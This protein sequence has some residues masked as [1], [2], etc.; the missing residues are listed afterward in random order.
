[1]FYRV[2]VFNQC[3]AR[4]RYLAHTGH[5]FQLV[6]PQQNPEKTWRSAFW[7]LPDN[8]VEVDWATADGGVRGGEYDLVLCQTLEDLVVARQ[9]GIPRLFVPLGLLG[10]EAGVSPAA[11]RAALEQLRPFLAGVAVAF[12]SEKQRLSWGLA[13][14]LLGSAVDPEEFAPATG[15]EAAVLRFNT[16]AADHLS[17]FGIQDAVLGGEFPSFI[18]DLETGQLDW[19]GVKDLLRRHRVLCSSLTEGHTVGYDA[20]VLAAMAAGMPVVSTANSA[21]PVVDGYNGFI[22]ND[23]RYLREKLH[24]VLS[25]PDLAAELGRNARQTVAE[26]FNIGDHV[27]AWNAAFAEC[28]GQTASGGLP[29]MVAAP[30]VSIAIPVFNK[31]EF[32]EACL[33]ALAENTDDDPTYEVIVINNASSDWTQYLLHAFEGDLRVEHNDENEGFARANNQAAAMAQGEYLLFLNNDTVVQPGWLRAMVQLADSDPSIGIVGAKLLYPESGTIQ[34]AG[35]E[36]INGVP[37][38]IHREVAA[39]DPRVNAVCDFD[40][41]T[42]ACMLVRRSL[43]IELAGFDEEFLNGV[44][45]VDLCL[46]AREL[47]WRVVYCPTSVVEHHEGSSEGRY[48]HVRENLQRFVDRW[49]GR[50]DAEGRLAIAAA[51]VAAT[52]RKVS[53]VVPQPLGQRPIRGNWEGPFL[54]YA[55]LATVNRELVLA[56]LDDGRCELGLLQTEPSEMADAEI[57]ERLGPIAEGLDQ[58]LAGAIDFHLRHHW[59]PDF[60]RPAA[61]KLV[62][63]QPWEFGRIP[64]DWVE[65]IGENVAQIWAYTNYV[66]DCYIASGIDPDIVEVVRLGVDVKR[67]HPGLSGLDLPTDKTCKFLFVGGTLERKGIDCLLKA[68]RSVFTPDDDVCLVIKDMGTRSFYENQTAGEQIRA[69]QNDPHCAD[70]LYLTEDLP[71]ADIPRLYAACDCLVHPY[72]GEGFGLPV[73]EAMACGLPVVVTQGGACDDFCNAETAYLVPARRIGVKFPDGMEAAGQPW[74]LEPDLDQLKVQLRQVFA[75]R[76]EARQRGALA[77]EHIAGHFTWQH[78][79]QDAYA[80]LAKLSQQGQTLPASTPSTPVAE[81]TLVVLGDVAEAAVAVVM[82]GLGSGTVRRDIRGGAETSL[83]AELEVVR[84]ETQGDFLVFI[85]KGEIVDAAGVGLLVEHLRHQQDIAVALPS[86]SGEAGEVGLVELDVAEGGLFVFRRQALEAIGG[87]NGSF[88]TEAVLCEAGRQIGRQGGRVVRVLECAMVGKHCP[89]DAAYGDEL[90]SVRSLAE[91]DRMRAVGDDEAALVAY[92]RAVAAK[93]NFVEAIVVLAALLMESGQPLEATEYL[94]GLVQMDQDS[95]QAHN[96]LGL[97]HYQAGQVEKARSIM[98]RAHALNP[99]YVETLVNL[100][101]LE[102]EQGNPPQALDYLEKAAELEPDNRDVIV[103]TGIMYAQSGNPAA[104]ISLLR[105]YLQL[106]P[107]DGQAASSLADVLIQNGEF[108]AARELAED[109]LAL[110][111][112]YPVAQAILERIR[113]QEDQDQE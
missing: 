24:A 112:Q 35:I 54:V 107:R 100:A 30:R 82:A 44:E 25:A 57:G 69:L 26:H 46:R 6:H 56:L 15:A 21:S 18:A 47:G 49:Q 70:I 81:S 39:D 101:V 98:Q 36:L 84:R 8:V 10:T 96:Y 17:G 86:P 91:G 19:V 61:G 94:Q 53:G 111:P 16:G 52:A 73:A 11:R 99:T 72:R 62:L 65:P 28:L 37:D 40:M 113:G 76:E 77:A 13:G 103:N 66:R 63:M 55:S 80:A 9:W 79:A 58:P 22:S 2:L 48:D 50:F 95:F 104:G 93:G 43:F 34:H 68:Y 102:W 59:P 1:M 105:E 75:H 106:N 45:D 89:L 90:E 74:M 71:E 31:A 20:F 108:A 110:D 41:V 97:A 23:Y 51:A 64:V 87:F 109:L 14:S 5:S 92:R 3:E 85:G 12:Y 88:R 42:G 29:P 67:F 32:T 7:P 83:S 38:H 33:F 60:S 78:A 27:A 4:L